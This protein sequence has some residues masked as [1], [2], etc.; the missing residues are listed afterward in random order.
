[1][2]GTT[3]LWIVFSLFVFVHTIIT[4][5]L[6]NALEDVRESLGRE[7]TN[8]QLTYF[9]L[10]RCNERDEDGSCCCG[11]SPRPDWDGL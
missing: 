9:K 1:M 8:R 5:R 7:V 6:R 3:V 2:S 10:E 4:F 11:V